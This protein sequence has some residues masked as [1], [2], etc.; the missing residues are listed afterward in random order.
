MCSG[1]DCE[2]MSLT[3]VGSWRCWWHPSLGRLS[4]FLYLLYIWGCLRGSNCCFW[5]LALLADSGIYAFCSSLCWHDGVLV[6]KRMAILDIFIHS[7]NRRTVAGLALTLFRLPCAPW[8]HCIRI[9]TFN[10]SR[11]TF[12][13]IIL[14]LFKLPHCALV[15]CI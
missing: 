10:G 2:H 7:F 14:K 15:C 3:F 5:L 4:R 13:G 11:G 12:A 6:G 9:V 1:G 8:Y